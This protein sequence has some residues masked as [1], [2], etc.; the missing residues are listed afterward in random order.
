MRSRDSTIVYTVMVAQ[1]DRATDPRQRAYRPPRPRA[2][3][4]LTDT[5]VDHSARAVE[6]TP[7]S[8]EADGWIHRVTAEAGSLS[9]QQF[10]PEDLRVIRPWLGKRVDEVFLAVPRPGTVRRCAASDGRFNQS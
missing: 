2:A 6:T 10:C 7:L 8:G 3:K 1:P 9:G 4:R 5:L